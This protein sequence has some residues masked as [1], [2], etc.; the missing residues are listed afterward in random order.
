VA[1]G[2]LRQQVVAAKFAVVCAFPLKASPLVANLDQQ[3]LSEGDQ[4]APA[5]ATR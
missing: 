4:L 3:T 2:P 5:R 1:T